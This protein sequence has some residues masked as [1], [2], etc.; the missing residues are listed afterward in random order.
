[1]F[2]YKQRKWKEKRREENENC[3]AAMDDTWN[4]ES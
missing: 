4:K 3:Y 1:M 2:A